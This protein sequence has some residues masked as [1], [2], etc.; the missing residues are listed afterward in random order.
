[1]VSKTQSVNLPHVLSVGRQAYEIQNYGSQEYLDR[2]YDY[3]LDFFLQ[4]GS[5]IAVEIHILSWT[6]RL[7]PFDL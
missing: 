2:E 3:H 1:D 6:V 4:G 7:Q 5:W